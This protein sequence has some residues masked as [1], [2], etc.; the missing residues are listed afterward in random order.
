[1]GTSGDLLSLASK[2]LNSNS[3][4]SRV[5]ENVPISDGAPVD[6]L[7]HKAPDIDTMRWNQAFPYQLIVVKKNVGD[8]VRWGAGQKGWTYTLPMPPESMTIQ[9]PFA[10]Q[11]WITMGGF[12]EEHNGAPLRMIHMHGSFGVNF[13]RE[14][15]STP[16]P[17]TG[18]LQTIF[19]GTISAYKSVK[20]GATKG[21]IQ[22]TN[23]DDQSRY[24]K[25]ADDLEKLTGWYQY[26]VLQ[27]FFENYAALK[28]TTEG[29][30]ARLAL[31]VWKD[32][33]VYLV[34]PM[35]FQVNKS[36][37]SPLEYIYD[38]Q[39]KATKRVPLETGIGSITVFQ[40]PL[41]QRPNDLAAFQASIQKIRLLLQ[42]SKRVI[43]AVGRDIAHAVFETVREMAMLVKDVLGLPLAIADLADNII[44]DL[45]ATIMEVGVSTMFDALKEGFARI[46]ADFEFIG[47]AGESSDN[48]SNI[49]T[50]PSAQIFNN[51]KD[52]FDVLADLPVGSLQ[53]PPGTMAKIAEERDRISKLGREHWEERRLAIATIAAEFAVTVGMGSPTFNRT[54]GLTI[55]PPAVATVPTEE[56]YDII[57]ALNQLVIELNKLV[58]TDE[59]EPQARVDAIDSVAGMAARSGIAFTVP[60]GKYAVPFP[61]GSS[62]EMLAA[63]YLQDPNRWHEI[64]ALNGLQTPYVDEEGFELLLLTNGADS[65][66]MVADASHLFVGQPVWLES[67]AASREKRRINKIEKLS[68]NQYLISVSGEAD[69]D[70]YGTLARA[71]LR[72]FLPNTVNSQQLIHIPSDQA[73]DEGNF[74]SRQ[75]PGV[76]EFD[77]FLQVG[78][79][80]LLLTS[81]NDLV[82]TPNGDS[83]WAF[84]LTNIVQK[85]RLAVG[86]RQGTLLQHPEYGLPL[87]VGMSM[88]D[89]HPVDV[90]KAAEAMFQR[91]PS[92]AGV[93]AAR[94]MVDGPTVH[95]GIAVEVAGT[96]QI[97]PV[98]IEA[99]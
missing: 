96:S 78:G 94:V 30:A 73:P 72:A 93:K 42:G 66:V 8:Y 23:V 74:R 43:A 33:S 21:A 55:V 3:S 13:G 77:R 18:F 62:L 92:F 84:G 6:L 88:A 34:Q 97:I 80:D 31:A 91:D 35:S 14:K 98:S 85:L 10:I 59:H 53:I 58:V 87:E 67:R 32:E 68:G 56:D 95:L 69:L 99:R 79:K 26:R 65:R 48:K 89:L 15:N 39:F 2:F 25:K 61:Y 44:R 27:T 46:G 76:D 37:Q 81:S 50:H 38:L 54:Y 60:R 29:R 7:W 4:L 82:I 51:P 5:K 86:T 24:A 11:T 17:P 28:K 83:R 22:A 16:E 47:F 64:A 71:T 75:I 19:A 70:K 12:V 45:H 49:E 90:A 52:H 40:P 41:L 20:D 57:F 9:M 1:M 63:R 36:A